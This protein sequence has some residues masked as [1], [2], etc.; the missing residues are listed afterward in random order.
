[1][2]LHL[3]FSHLSLM[4]SVKLQCLLQSETVLCLAGLVCVCVCVCVFVYFKNTLVLSYA[5][6]GVI[7][8]LK[9]CSRTVDEKHI[10]IDNLERT[11]NPKYLVPLF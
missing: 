10:E 2:H 6:H 1:M 3:N 9:P 8:V 7:L 11:G 4:P 5:G